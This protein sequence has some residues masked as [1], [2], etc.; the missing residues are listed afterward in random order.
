[1][2]INNKDYRTI[3]F[4]EDSNSVKV[5]DQ[6]LLPFDF[7]IV[8]VN[9]SEFMATIIMDMYV[10]GAGLIG[11]SAAWGIYLA[12]RENSDINYI[13]ASAEILAMTRPTAVNLQAAIDIMLPQLQAAQPENRLAL[14]K[15][16]AEEI[17]DNDAFS[18]KTIGEKGYD[19]INKNIAKGEK[20]R[21]NIL[22]HCNAGW[23]AFV[24]YGS[25]LAPI[26][27]AFNNG[28][29]IHVYVDE[30]RPRNQG[31]R[32]TA[33]ELGQHGVPHTLIA[34]NVGGHLMQN[35]MVDMVIVGAD[36][37]ANNGDVANKI[38]TYL[39]ALAA[40]DNNVPFVVAFPTSTFD[41]NI[42]N[43]VKDIPI[44][45]RDSSEVLYMSGLN[46]SKEVEVRIAPLTTDAVNFGFDVTP[47]RL[48]NAYFTEKGIFT[49]PEEMSKKL[50]K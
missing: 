50:S 38:G 35:G 44:E 43:G 6:R 19:F 41:A 31:A 25:A 18:C 28:M 33:W 5:I 20:R 32:L 22:T 4:S 49:S 14:A 13:E 24:D 1:M 34:D 29:D 16:L 2:K 26:Y 23:L 40:A 21:I 39:K 27:E 11:A 7:T 30:T 9:T 10:R 46:N 15:K 48:I 37:V 42:Q 12:V 8:D 45:E 47:S 3:W 36:R 17:T